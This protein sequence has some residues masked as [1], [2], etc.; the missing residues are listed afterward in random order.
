MWH[1]TRDM[2]HKTSDMWHLTDEGRWNFSQN[3]RSPAHTVWEWRYLE[4]LE[5][6]DQ[7]VIELINEEGVCRKKQKKHHKQDR[8]IHTTNMP[9]NTHHTQLRKIHTINRPNKFTPLAGHTNTYNNYAW[10]K[11]H[12]QVRQNTSLTGQANTQ[13]KQA[14]KCTPQT[15]QKKHTP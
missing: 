5:E 10:K 12:R 9:K 11:T 1:V 4:D 7:S 13:H 2:L 3:F 14:H 15:C 6:K 8:Q